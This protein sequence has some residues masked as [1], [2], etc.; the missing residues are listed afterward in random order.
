MNMKAHIVILLFCLSQVGWAQQERKTESELESVTVFLTRAQEFRKAKV[1]LQSGAQVLVFDQLS[2]YIDPQSIQVSGKGAATILGVKHQM[3]YLSESALPAPIRAL[4]DSL[5]WYEKTI[6][7]EQ[8]KLGII[9]KEE[10]MI[11]SNQVIGGKDKNLTVIELKAMAD[12][13]RTR[14]EELAR[15]KTDGEA[16][17]K[18]Y[19]ARV[20]ALQNQINEWRRGW[21]RNTSEIHV[22]VAA[23]ARTTVDM[24]LSF[25]VGNAGWSP[26]YD[27]RAKD[28]KS[29]VELQYKAQVYQNTGVDWKNVRLKLSTANPS[30]GGVKP[31]L[32]PWWI[33]IFVPAPPAPQVMRA[34]R[35]EIQEMIVFA[36]KDYEEES[37]VQTF[38]KM[39]TVAGYSQVTQTTLSTEFE[40]KIP[41]TV[42]GSGK[43]VVVDIGSYQLPV[44]F[45]HSSA[46][47][48]DQDVFLMAGISGWEQYD[49]LP[50]PANVFFEGGYIGRSQIQPRVMGDTLQMSLG[51][52]KKVVVTREKMKDF[53]S[54]RV[55]GNNKREQ[56]AYKI[57]IRNTKNE[58][59]RV[60]VEDQIPVSQSSEIEVSLQEAGGGQL[61]KQSGKI[62]WEVELKPNESREILYKFEVKYPKSRQVT[63]L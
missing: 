6:Q 28:T 9:D 60:R 62:I 51:R 5:Q 63:G 35:P 56:F 46:P 24:Q 22:T 52:D 30:L 1:Q 45:T 50:G 29:P 3:S 49:L 44:E 38:S 19:R 23:D 26:Q 7:W 14:L 12:F 20:S 40:I 8:Q 27:I 57:S 54:T 37:D 32:R 53:T 33:T 21:N 31:E 58:T 61:D 41:Y 39:S 2:P 15:S 10:K 16:K 48:L 47:K 17:V 11:M 4:Q 55:I 34:Q 13:F 59:I 18:R 25:V 43:P 36:D 42:A